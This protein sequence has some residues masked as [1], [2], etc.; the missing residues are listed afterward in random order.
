MG[1]YLYYLVFVGHQQG[2]FTNWDEVRMV[3]EGFLNARFKCY[4]TLRE[5]QSAHELSEHWWAH[6]QVQQEI[7]DEPSSTPNSIPMNDEESN[8]VATFKKKLAWLKG[9]MLIGL[10]VILRLLMK[11]LVNRK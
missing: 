6:E 4:R 11:D 8:D 5:A 7:V 10:G 1:K 2:I 3:M 9:L